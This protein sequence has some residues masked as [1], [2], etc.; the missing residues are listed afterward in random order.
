[1]AAVPDKDHTAVGLI[2]HWAAAEERHSRLDCITKHSKGIKLSI[3]YIAF[4]LANARTK[5]PG[6]L[7]FVFAPKP[8]SVITA[9]EFL[10]PGTEKKRVGHYLFPCVPF[11]ARLDSIRLSLAESEKHA[12]AA[13]QK[14]DRPKKQ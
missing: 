14:R 3:N 8:S 12:G 11:P 10:E 2:W 1:M 4:C 6:P 9:L 5:R 13:A 7:L